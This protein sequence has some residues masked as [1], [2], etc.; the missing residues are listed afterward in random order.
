MQKGKLCNWIQ[1]VFD[2]PSS[3]R[4][5][6]R[7]EVEKEIATEKGSEFIG[8]VPYIPFVKIS[9]KGF[10]IDTCN[11]TTLVYKVKDLPL[12]FVSGL[13]EVT[14]SKAKTINPEIDAPDEAPSWSVEISKANS[15]L[16]K[17]AAKIALDGLLGFKNGKT[18]TEGVKLLN[19]LKN[20]CELLGFVPHIA[21]VREKAANDSELNA[22]WIH[23]FAQRTLLYKIKGVSCLL[24]AN[25]SIH[26]ND[27]A[28]RAIKS[29]KHIDSLNY[30]AGITG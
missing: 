5:S 10:F 11:S 7:K 13:D 18:S 27:S 12:L 23:P 24:I 30:I 16:K 17:E 20:E 9:S 14:R 6:L 25:S 3:A 4:V 28:L 29:N 26:F 21:Y 1:D 15:D 19:Y 2:S 22:L 8:F